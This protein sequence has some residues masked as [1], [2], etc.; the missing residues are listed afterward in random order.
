MMIRKDDL[1]KTPVENVVKRIATLKEE[2]GGVLKVAS[3]GESCGKINSVAAD[4]QI[5]EIEEIVNKTM[6]L[7]LGEF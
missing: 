7:K 3:V 2:S 5:S 6:E 1:L 4:K